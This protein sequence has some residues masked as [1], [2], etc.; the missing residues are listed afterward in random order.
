MLPCWEVLHQGAL[1]AGRDQG[2]ARAARST[3]PLARARAGMP[4]HGNLWQFSPF[5]A[6]YGIVGWVRQKEAFLWRA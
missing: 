5:T 2:S 3:R 6:I 4:K 1:P